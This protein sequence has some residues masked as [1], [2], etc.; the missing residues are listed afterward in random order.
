MWLVV[1]P[2]VPLQQDWPDNSPTRRSDFC[3]NN[4]AE[5]LHGEDNSDSPIV[6]CWTCLCTK[7]VS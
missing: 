3:L 7:Q 5:I 6:A 4:D 1:I 2:T